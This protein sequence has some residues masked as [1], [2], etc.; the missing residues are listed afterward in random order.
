MPAPP[1][2][3]MEPLR[4]QF[5]VWLPLCVGNHSLIWSYARFSGTGRVR[6]AR[7]GPGAGAV[8]RKIRDSCFTTSWAAM[9]GSLRRHCPFGL[10][11]GGK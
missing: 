3:L 1:S 7:S 8:K 2:S 6:Q 5:S 4:V 10:S 11:A 9:G